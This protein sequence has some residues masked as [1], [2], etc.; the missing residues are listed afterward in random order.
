MNRRS[1]HRCFPGAICAFLFLLFLSICLPAAVQ[2][3]SG[4]SVR[5]KTPGAAFTPEGRGVTVDDVPG[6]RRFRGKPGARVTIRGLLAIPAPKSGEPR[7]QGLVV[8]FRTSPSGPRLRAVEMRNGSNVEFRIDTNLRGDYGARETTTPDVGANAWIWR[9]PILVGSRSLVRLELTFPIGFDSPIDPGEFVLLDISADFPRS[10]RT[11]LES[12]VTL[13][14]ETISGLPR[15]A[16]AAA[17]APAPG[18][19]KQAGLIYAVGDND[20]LLWYDH[21]GHEEGT[22][23][24]T[25]QLGRVVGTRW[26]FRQVFSGGDG[27]VYAITPEDDL[28]WYRHEGRGDGTF[29]WAPNSGTRVGTGWSFEHVFYGGEGVI[30]AITPDGDLL[31]YRHDDR[32]DGG[33]RWAAGGQGRKIGE[34]WAFKHVFA[35]GGGVIYAVTAEDDLLWYRHDGRQDGSPTWAAPAGRKVGSE[36]SFK[37][38]FSSGDGVIYGVTENGDLVWYRHDGRGD[39]TFR[40]A[41]PS[42]TRVGTG[43]HFK[44][45]F[46]GAELRVWAP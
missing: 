8:H 21:V 40:W 13:S 42:G 38:V 44:T 5:V 18:P 35:G 24:W 14:H 30:Y 46:S 22:S 2:G 3:D 16:K 25:A 33:T 7:M 43:W 6:G 17:P 45:V 23:T 32:D 39:G 29:R 4:V 26:A 9:D 28:L 20:D 31:W 27:V 37:H 12:A 19:A 36:W 34:G 1:E 41:A 15:P 10:S 11:M